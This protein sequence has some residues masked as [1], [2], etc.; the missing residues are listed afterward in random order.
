MKTNVAACAMLLALAAGSGTAWAQSGSGFVRGIGGVTFGT[1]DPGG[2]FGGGIGKDVAPMLQ[3]AGDAGR[4]SDILPSELR[5]QLQELGDI[6]SSLLGVP[7]TLDATAPAFY[8]AA[9]ARVLVPSDGRLQ[10]FLEV[11]GGIVRV[12]FDVAASVGSEDISDI[13]EEQLDLETASDFLM[14]FGGGVGI[15]VTNALGVEL[16]Y[17]Y[18]RIFSDPAIHSHAA[19]GGVRFVFP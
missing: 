4:L 16:G 13:L 10:P 6:Y 3:I 15:G 17:R 7:V 1:A 18:H 5:D 8:A 19:Y 9:G 12:S 11:Q 14:V 2:L